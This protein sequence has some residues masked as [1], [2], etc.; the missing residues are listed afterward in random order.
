MVNNS[1]QETK[2]D[3]SDSNNYKETFDPGERNNSS[4]FAHQTRAH[5]TVFFTLMIKIV[6]ISNISICQKFPRL[7][8][9]CNNKRRDGCKIRFH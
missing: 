5:K 7:S 3:V 6:N 1:K 8:T 4:G 9:Y 2:I